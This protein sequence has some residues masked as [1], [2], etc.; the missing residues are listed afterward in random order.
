MYL[1]YYSLLFFFISSSIL[2]QL[3]PVD[4]LHRHYAEYYININIDSVFYYGNLLKSSNDT[5]AQYDGYYRLISAYYKKGD[6]KK[7]EELTNEL[8]QLIGDSD[9]K[10]LRLLKLES[11]N[12][13]FWIYK[14][15][16]RPDKIFQVSLLL[17]KLTD[18]FDQNDSYFEKIDNLKKSIIANIKVELTLYDEAIK[19]LKLL[20]N[21]TSNKIPNLSGNKKYRA[22]NLKSNLLNRIGRAFLASSSYKNDPLIDSASFYFKKAYEVS[23]LFNPKHKDSELH[24]NLESIKIH[25]KR[26]NYN[27]ALKQLEYTEKIDIEKNELKEIY[28]HKSYA[29]NKINEIDSSIFYANKFLNQHK[30]SQITGKNEIQIYKNL[31]EMYRLKNKIDSTHKYLSIANKKQNDLF[32]NHN[33]N[34]KTPSPL[35]YEKRLRYQLI[36]IILMFFVVSFNYLHKKQQKSKMIK[37][38]FIQN[39]KTSQPKNNQKYIKKELEQKLLEKLLVF[40]KSTLFLD[41]KFNLQILA[42][43]LKTNTSYLSYIINEK[44]GRTFKQYT[45]ELRIN[46]LLRE[47]D[48]N[49]QLRKYTIKALGKEIGYTDAS[50]FTRAFKNFTGKSPSEYISSLKN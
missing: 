28:F 2:G 4:S 6:Y 35:T 45:T 8:I 16:N 22:L 49:H 13:L 48:N 26:E 42:K 21:K 10:Y 41:H 12:K 14:N 27:E 15:I 47:I 19:I 17:E 1:R 20:E 29:L 5:T 3:N 50:A 7:S 24:F 11:Y 31:A 30:N 37:K 25:I 32:K 34:F 43:K 40:E 23:K 36:L 39:K 46:Y 38:I 33:E 9:N 18:D 44:K